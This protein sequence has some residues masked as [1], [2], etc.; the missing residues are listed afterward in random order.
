MRRACARKLFLRQL[1]VTTAPFSASVTVAS[2]LGGSAPH[3]PSLPLRSASRAPAT[4][5]P[6]LAPI[7]GD[8]QWP[9]RFI[10]GI[11]LRRR[12]QMAEDHRGSR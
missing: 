5:L 7:V 4:A 8:D 2:K 12:A 1:R 3:V 9:C 6:G 10:S 11:S